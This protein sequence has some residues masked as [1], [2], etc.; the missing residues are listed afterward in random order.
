MYGYC[1]DSDIGREF[2]GDDW[3][4]DLRESIILYS[5]YFGHST[6]M[7]LANVVYW[8]EI[9][10][11]DFSNYKDIYGNPISGIYEGFGYVKQGIRS[12]FY[13]QLKK[14]NKEGFIHCFR[15]GYRAIKGIGGKRNP[16]LDLYDYRDSHQ[17]PSDIVSFSLRKKGFLEGKRLSG[18]YQDVTLRPWEMHRLLVRS[19]E[20]AEKLLG[21]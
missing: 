17:R 15:R 12:S 10:E 20:V 8:E 3:Y 13:K 14:L 2:V 6:E 16:V 1:I 7:T 19:K 5:P 11:V 4:S 21:K 9:D 18:M